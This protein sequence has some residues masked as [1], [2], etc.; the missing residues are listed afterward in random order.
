VYY[1]AAFDEYA[2][3]VLRQNLTNLIAVGDAE[4]RRFACNLVAVGKRAV[5]PQG[6]P[7]LAQALRRRGYRVFELDFSEFI[8]AGGA[9][10]CLTLRLA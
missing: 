1:P 3:R 10:K 4:A 6:C 7:L 5:I 8:K 9:A 2:Q